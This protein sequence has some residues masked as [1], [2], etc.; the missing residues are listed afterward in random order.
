[1]KLK[2]VMTWQCGD[3][4]RLEHVQTESEPSDLESPGWSIVK[5]KTGKRRE[6][7]GRVEPLLIEKLTWWEHLKK[8]LGLRRNGERDRAL[9]RLEL[10]RSLLRSAGGGG[11]FA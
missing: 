11:G 7:C 6:D 4:P 9:W 10:G 3:F 2:A 1:M 5:L 8:D